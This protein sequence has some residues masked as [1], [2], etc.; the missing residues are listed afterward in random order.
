MRILPFPIDN[1]E[2]DIFVRWA[3]GKVQEDRLFVARLFHNLICGRLRLVDKIW[4][5]YIELWPLVSKIA[6]KP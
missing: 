1:S 5:K 3:G 6:S 2:R 4:V